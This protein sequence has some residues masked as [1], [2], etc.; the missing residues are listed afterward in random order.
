MAID[1]VTDRL[2]SLE[3]FAGLPL[4]TVSRIADIAD[5]I[6]YRRGQIIAQ[7]GEDCDGAIVIIAGQAMV[8]ADESRGIEVE[9][10]EPG[11]LIGEISMISEHHL[12]VSIMAVSSN[13]KAVKIRRDAMHALMQEDPDLAAHFQ[14]RLTARLSRLILDLKLID[15]RLVLATGLPEKKTIGN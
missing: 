3:A 14:S 5:R 1:I 4:E 7:A 2:A 13:V 12:S 11:T 9:E 8:L 15:E 10:V 6:I